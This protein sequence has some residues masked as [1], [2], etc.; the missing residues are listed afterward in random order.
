MTPELFSL[1]QFIFI[2]ACVSLLNHDIIYDSI[3]NI[4]SK[5]NKHKNITKLIITIK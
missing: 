1:K 2:L 3:T 4:I 5:L